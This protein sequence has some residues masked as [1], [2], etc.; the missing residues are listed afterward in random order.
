MSVKIGVASEMVTQQQKSGSFTPA[1]KKVSNYFNIA[2]GDNIYRLLPPF[3]DLADSGTWWVKTV[4]HW[5]YRNSEGKARTFRCLGKGCPECAFIKATQERMQ[6]LEKALP[7]KPSQEELAPVKFLA[8]VLK[9][10]NLQITYDVNALNQQNQ[11]GLLRIKTKMWQTFGAKYEESWKPKNIH[12]AS[13]ERGVWIN[14]RKKGTGT[15]AILNVTDVKKSVEI[16]GEMAE[17]TAIHVLNQDVLNR[18]E[19]EAFDLNKVAFTLEAEKVQKL[20]NSMIDSVA[21]PGVVDSVFG[22]KSET[23]SDGFNDDLSKVWGK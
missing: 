22:R 15:T 5:G 16:E 6:A 10:H 21:D 17:V 8:A 4:V 13:V 14:F 9:D 18:L 3:G 12:P 19:N 23:E 1:K 2:E 7:A 11:I 20:V